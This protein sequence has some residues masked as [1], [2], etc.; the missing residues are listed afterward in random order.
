LTP[1][2][3]NES[4]QIPARAKLHDDVLRKRRF[5]VVYKVDDVD[6][7]ELSKELD[8]HDDCVGQGCV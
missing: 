8:L 1:V 3:V 6:V 5:D 7:I 4:V 2:A